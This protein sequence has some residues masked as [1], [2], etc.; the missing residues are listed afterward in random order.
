MH[1]LQR[2][3]RG[4]TWFSPSILLSPCPRG[5][6]DFDHPLL[7]LWHLQAKY[8]CPHPIENQSGGEREVTWVGDLVS[9]PPSFYCLTSWALQMLRSLELHHILW[10]QE[11]QLVGTFK[12]LTASPHCRMGRRGI[13]ALRGKA[14][15]SLVKNFSQMF[16][17]PNNFWGHRRPTFRNFYCF[18]GL[19]NPPA[20]HFAVVNPHSMILEAL[21]PRAAP[22]FCGCTA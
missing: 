9:T 10:K 22:Q 11:R 4:R 2:N 16:A 5:R 6:F 3:S 21:A 19:P 18:L 12:S 8:G 1:F 14:I 17:L 7:M 15:H 13:Q 20:K